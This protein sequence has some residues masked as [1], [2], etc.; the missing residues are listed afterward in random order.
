MEPEY[1]KISE[2]AKRMSMHTRT[3]YRQFHSGKVAGYQDEDTGTIYI[4]N[5]FKE[6]LVDTEK[7]N[8][9][10]LYARVSSSQNKNNL[11]TQMERLRMFATVKGYTVVKEV[12]EIGSGLNDKRPKLLK[13]LTTDLE[14]YG[15]LLVEHNDRLAR[16]GKPYIEALLTSHG[17]KLEVINE[18]VEDE[19]DLIQDFVSIITSYCARIYGKRR[20][21]RKTEQLIKDLKE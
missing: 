9:V 7:S 17:K 13:L 18:V 16:F 15:I 20:S 19:E 10:V 4:L 8:Q 11:E 5:P 1:I 6:T 12:K 2:Y 14:D 21:K 3:A